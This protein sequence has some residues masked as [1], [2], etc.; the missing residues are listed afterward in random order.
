MTFFYYLVLFLFLIVTSLLAFTVVI[1]DSKNVGMS[2]FLAGGSSDSLFGAS[3]ADVVKKI[4]AYLA[5]MFFV[6]CI[7]LSVWSSTIQTIQA[8][9]STLQEQ[10]QDISE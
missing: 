7:F 4:T 9:M 3:T 1:Q 2:A 5:I 6:G 8:P 10:P